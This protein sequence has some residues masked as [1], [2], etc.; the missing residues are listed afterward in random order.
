MPHGHFQAFQVMVLND[1]SQ[2]RPLEIPLPLTEGA[3]G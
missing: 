1:K 2:D 3:V